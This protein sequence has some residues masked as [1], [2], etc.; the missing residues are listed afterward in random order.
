MDA[1]NISR[2]TARV[3][4]IVHLCLVVQCNGERSS[5][6]CFDWPRWGGLASVV[7][8]DRTK[9][10]KVE[11]IWGKLFARKFKMRATW[12]VLTYV[13][14]TYV[15]SPQYEIPYIYVQYSKHGTP[16][17]KTKDIDWL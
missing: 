7:P 10:E 15:H 9:G 11:Q 17:R 13:E 3:S 8:M 14:G 6:Y 12:Y 5:F 2:V 16:V 4:D 1:E